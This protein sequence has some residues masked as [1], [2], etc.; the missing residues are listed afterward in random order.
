MKAL[1]RVAAILSFA[2]CFTAGSV[3]VGK[4]GPYKDGFLLVAAGLIF[5]GVAFFAGGILLAAAERFE[6]KNEGR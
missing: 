1:L 3:L 5:L 2:F 6:R 4:A